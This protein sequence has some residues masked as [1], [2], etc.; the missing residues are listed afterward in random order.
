MTKIK[1]SLNKQAKILTVTSI[2]IVILWQSFLRG[3]DYSSTTFLNHKAKPFQLEQVT[4]KDAEP[5]NLHK[6]ARLLFEKELG[7]QLKQQRDLEIQRL[8]FSNQ[9]NEAKFRKYHKDISLVFN[10]R[11]EYTQYLDQNQ[12]STERLSIMYKEA[13]LLIKFFED[14]NNSHDTFEKTKNSET[15]VLFTF[16]LDLITSALEN[17]EYFYKLVHHHNNNNKNNDNNNN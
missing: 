8:L 5:D 14:F 12:N 15:Q 9:T 6:E 10:R 16:G 1:G 17:A 3:F 4:V 7:K 2:I 13:N 11:E